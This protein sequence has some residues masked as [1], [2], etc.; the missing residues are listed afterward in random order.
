MNTPSRFRA[1]VEE[2][3][4]G[5]TDATIVRIA[6]DIAEVTGLA[7]RPPNAEGLAQSLSGLGVEAELLGVDAIQEHDWV[8]RGLSH[9]IAVDAG[10]FTLR[11]SHLPPCARARDDICIDAGLAFGTG[12]HPTTATVLDILTA[13][14]RYR[15]RPRKVLDVGTGS[16]VLA[17]AMARLWRCPVMAVD[18]DPDA[19]RCARVNVARNGVARWVQ[20]I[21]ADGHGALIGHDKY[22]VVAANLFASPLRALA[23]RLARCLVPGGHAVLAGLL[24][25][26]RFPVM[27]AYTD[28]GLAIRRTVRREG[29]LTLL[30]TRPAGER[31]SCP[32]NHPKLATAAALRRRTLVPTAD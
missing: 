10:R 5:I 19:V 32:T 8:A 23:P 15:D 2:M 20:V 22:D 24:D 26:Q 13:L 3:L 1:I 11:G 25:D 28:Q 14:A 4:L 29:W 12:H 7:E 16:G 31:W 30:L 17:I 6:G 9:L 21:E 27:R 18:N